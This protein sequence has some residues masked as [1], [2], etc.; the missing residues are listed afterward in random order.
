MPKPSTAGS[1]NVVVIVSIDTEEDN[2]GRNG[3]CVKTDNIAQLPRLAD[4]L[5]RFGARPTYFTAYQV[6][7]QQRAAATMLEICADGRGEIGGHLH[8]W[9][10]PPHAEQK[11]P[12]N[13]ML[14]NLPA[15]LQFEKLRHLTMALEE[16]FGAA[17]RAFRAGRFGLGSETIPALIRC[18]YGIDSSVAPFQNLERDGGPS[19]VGAPMEAYHLAP[20]A[21][22][23]EPAPPGQLLEIP[24]SCGFSRGP[25]SFW[26][27]TRRLLEAPPFRWLRLAG[28]AHRV[29]I[30]ERIMLSPEI[31]TADEMLLLSRRL[32]EH[33]VRHLQLFFHSPSLTPGLSPF[34][35][36]PQ[37]LESFY[38][39]IGSFLEGLDAIAPITFATMSEAAELL[40]PEALV[41]V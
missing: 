22:V 12:R 26:D 7:A 17:P 9:N 23:C 34:V 13:S 31:A 18:G 41:P 28:I 10:T 16:A 21:D 5:A 35:G 39:T 8:P 6:A 4:F 14:K 1:D 15:E 29:G 11:V 30:V 40:A 25:F 19:F 37:E 2:W 36:T 33:G 3:G 27:P 32:L 38:A 24:L 20:G